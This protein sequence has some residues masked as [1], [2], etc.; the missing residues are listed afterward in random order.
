MK[1][2]ISGIL[3]FTLLFGTTSV[4]PNIAE[5]F[6]NSISASA[7][8]DAWGR[9]YYKYGDLRCQD[10]KDGTV[11]I[12]GFD[13]NKTTAEIPE[14]ING[15]VVSE[16]G[17]NAFY[18]AEKLVS[19]EIPDTITYIG[20]NAFYNCVKLESIVL[21]PNLKEIGLKAFHSAGLK[22]I[23]FNNKL[24][25]IGDYA[26]AYTS[27]EK[28]TIPNNVKSIKERAFFSCPNLTY[29]KFPKKVDDFGSNVL[30]F[31]YALE[32]IVL[33]TEN[34]QVPDHLAWF[35][36]GLKNVTIPAGV[37]EIGPKAFKDCESLETVVIP[38]SVK[39]IGEGAF[40]NDKKLKNITLPDKLQ[41]IDSYAFRD[42]SSLE[43]ITLSKSVTQ[44]GKLAFKGCSN[45]TLY[46]YRNTSG[47]AYSLNNSI[48]H[49]YIEIDNVNNA[50]VSSIKDT[51]AKLSWDS[52]YKAQGYIIYK[53]DSAK[54]TWT[55]VAKSNNN[56][57]S[58]T[59]SK[60]SAGTTYKYAIVAY[61]NFNGKE[62][63]SDKKT[64]ISFTTL[65]PAVT[66]LKASS[67][68]GNS[69]KLSWSKVNGAEGYII[70]K[71]NTST[72]KWDRVAKGKY[73]ENYTVNKL[74]SLTS[75]KFAVKAYK[76]VNK[77]EITS[78]TYP[79]VSAKTV[80][81]TVTG[82]KASSTSTNQV[83]LTWNKVA[84]A[85]GYIVYKY[86]T[87]TKKWDRITKGKC[88]GTYTVSKLKS[89]T[90]YK[91]AVKAYK[92]VS[93]KEVLSASYPQL[94]T[95]TIPDTVKFS[96]TAGSK[97]ATI[98]WTKVTGASGYKLYY[99]TSKNGKWISLKT[100]NNKTT[101]YT[102]TGLTKGK[103]YWFT[104]K[105][106]RTSNNVTYNAAYT[107]KSVK[108]K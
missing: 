103:T 78:V 13:V 87:S 28:I 21:P 63:E 46:T 56:S 30:G 60:L 33:P 54:K 15:K 20:E 4:M 48:P 82:F 91:F 2:I 74:N 10:K 62:V 106:Y 55:K 8:T 31:C 51:T 71:Y 14:K 25:T 40:E 50:K 58:Y 89:G 47:A 95:S 7:D 19:V 12:I 101:S 86:N 85:D 57:T 29:I 107:T 64:E 93:G 3:A 43:N 75:Y 49:V 66:N 44:I 99:K 6:N 26:F 97:K 100:V 108:V 68:T 73:A 81:D 104:V 35:C 94:N 80:L 27:L 98:K 53:Y 23:M 83:K 96:L 70:Y 76:T 39:S 1:K 45:L 65:M 102:K 42:C 69:I 5:T 90:S 16:I 17:K 11:S 84:K 77:K 22:N 67:I 24:E 88:N 34:T 41:T 61:A 59:L 52:V 18:G 92:T 72:K 38:D 79:Q 36:K 105:A 9:E 37:T 32:E